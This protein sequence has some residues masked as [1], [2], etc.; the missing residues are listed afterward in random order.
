[1]TNSILND[2]SFWL[3]ISAVFVGLY[4]ITIAY[5]LKS[6]CKR[7]N[8]CFGCIKTERDVEVELKEELYE[9]SHNIN[10]DKVLEQKSDEV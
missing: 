3:G 7:C 8:I 5:T 10:I 1:M 2:A 9:I 6:K 4:K